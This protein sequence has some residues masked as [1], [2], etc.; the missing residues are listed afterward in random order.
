MPRE[1][2]GLTAAVLTIATV[3]GAR[4]QFIKAAPVSRA[5][6]ARQNNGQAQI[7][8]RLIHTGQHYDHEL[9]GEFFT[10]L[11]LPEPALNLAV[12]SGP[13]GEQTAAILR[14]LEAALLA[15]PPDLV[16]IYGD[17]NST[18]AAALVAAKLGVPLAH[19][20]AGLRSYNRAMPE[21]INRVIAD[22]LSDI[23]FTG[24]QAARENLENE[25]LGAR[26]REVGDVMYDCVRLFKLASQKSSN[27]LDR[28]GL[29]EDGYAL[30]TI[31]RAE[32]T[33][34]CERLAALVDD[35]ARIAQKLPVYLPLHPR[36]KRA[37]ADFGLDPAAA[38]IRLGPP[39]SFLEMMALE[40][41][42]R[43]ILTDSGGVQK[44]AYFHGVPCVTLRGETEWVE[45]VESGWNRLAQPGTGTIAAAADDML[46]LDRATPRPAC[47]GDGFAAE[48]IVA[49]LVAWRGGSLA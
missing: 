14:R 30:A 31:H 23:L 18:L 24:T 42:A 15:E 25:G 44:E 1:A 41:G 22:K 11:G 16:L 17:T 12:G 38:G 19:V 8:E 10:E 45:T 20:E 21:E 37:L 36:T 29:D 9:S 26:I 46:A 27:M 35:V 7:R 33:D 32:N 5:L 28:I 13:H 48:H 2:P 49:E 6:A 3:V 4:P 43:L 47:Y 39:A 34:D 40:A